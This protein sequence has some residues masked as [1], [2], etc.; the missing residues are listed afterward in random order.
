M[1]YLIISIFSF[2]AFQAIGQHE[3]SYEDIFE[4]HKN[5]SNYKTTEYKMKHS[6]GNLII[7]GVADVS[8]ESYSGSEIILS[9]YIRIKD[10]KEN[11]RSKGLKVLDSR[12]IED[13]TGLGYSLTKDGNNLILATLGNAHCDCNA[14]TIKLP[15]G[16]GLVVEDKTFR[17]ETVWVRNFQDPIEMSLKQHSIHL[18]NV[19]GPMAVKTLY[20]HVEAVFNSVSQ[21]GS[22]SLVAV[23]SF[24]DVSLPTATKA[25]LTLKTNHGE[26]YSDINISIDESASKSSVSHKVITGKINGGGVNMTINSNYSEVYLRKI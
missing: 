15:K 5:N 2:L 3:H 9:S 14:L 26:I 24:V 20:G 4:K 19:T 10:K 8:I 23:H 17:G 1:K 11:E 13:N 7:S 22:I 6:G 21:E 16:I 18:E 25:D 12:G